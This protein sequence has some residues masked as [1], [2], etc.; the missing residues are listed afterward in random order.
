MARVEERVRTFIREN[1]VMGDKAGDLKAEDSLMDMGIIDSTGV[2]E[3]IA[4]LEDG[5]GLEI[6]DD[7]LVP[8][9]LDSIANLC[10]FIARKSG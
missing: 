4:F 2:L 1:F 8:E 6:S 7:E 10:A 9:E 3:L 5:F